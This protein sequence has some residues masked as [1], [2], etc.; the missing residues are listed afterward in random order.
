MFKEGQ[1]V[2]VYIN[3]VGYRTAQI[4]RPAL[5]SF[6]VEYNGELYLIQTRFL[7]EWNER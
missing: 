3:G 2:R 6:W 7:I 1:K 5:N 4:V